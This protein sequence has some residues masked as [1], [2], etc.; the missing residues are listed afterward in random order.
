MFFS[1]FSVPLSSLVGFEGND[2]WTGSMLANFFI[3][4][5]LTQL[6]SDQLQNEENKTNINTL[7]STL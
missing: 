5:K 2:L 1:C 3:G 7:K 6:E 4:K